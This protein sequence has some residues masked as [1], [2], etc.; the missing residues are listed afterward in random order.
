MILYF[1]KYLKEAYWIIK[2]AM[3]CKFTRRLLS[4]NKI[5]LNSKGGMNI[6]RRYIIG[7]SFKFFE[8]DFE[9]ANHEH[10]LNFF[11]HIGGEL[12][13]IASRRD[14]QKE[15]KQLFIILASV[16]IVFSLS[17]LHDR[18]RIYAISRIQRLIEKVNFQNWRAHQWDK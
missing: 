11:E 9:F 18:G 4:A 8:S 1:L 3:Y 14:L 12:E 17:I 6:A 5:P 10:A 13:N 15:D 16:L 2:S 7:K